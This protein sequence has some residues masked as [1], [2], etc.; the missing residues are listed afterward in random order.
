MAVVTLN[1]GGIGGGR[2]CARLHKRGPAKIVDGGAYST[3]D[4]QKAH[5]VY[6]VNKRK[7]TLSND[8]NSLHNYRSSWHCRLSPVKC[9]LG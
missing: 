1:Q 6:Y 7:R 5:N 4:A 3:E 8:N 9:E 2:V